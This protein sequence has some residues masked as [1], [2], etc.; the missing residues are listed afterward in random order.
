VQNI[1]LYELKFIEDDVYFKYKRQIVLFSILQIQFLL[2]PLASSEVGKT[3]PINSHGRHRS[4][5]A[6]HPSYGENIGLQYGTG[7]VMISYLYFDL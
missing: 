2:C 4:S 7:S 6:F 5:S 1:I 3:K